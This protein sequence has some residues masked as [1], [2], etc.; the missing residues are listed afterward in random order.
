MNHKSDLILIVETTQT[1]DETLIELMHRR[2]P[3]CV[4]L[5]YDAYSRALYG[6]ILHIVQN[7]ELAEEVLQDTF[8]KAWRNIDRYDTRKGRLYTWLVNIARNSAID[9]TRAKHFNR[10]NASIE[11]SLNSIDLRQNKCLNTDTI[12]IQNLTETLPPYYKILID[13]I[14]FQG[15]TQAETAE[16]LS[17]PIGTV[18]THLR[19]AMT[20]LKRLF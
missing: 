20:I 19:T 9:A 2:D 6:I 7:R 13:L 11:S 14:Y 5:L 18:K 10:R 17:I 3:K 1:A 15:F 16:Y 4:S 8:T 12:G